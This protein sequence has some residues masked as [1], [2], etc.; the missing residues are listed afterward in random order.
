ML[1]YWN[2]PGAWGL[3]FGTSL[4]AGMAGVRKAGTTGPTGITRCG[5]T[6]AP[7]TNEFQRF[8]RAVALRA[9]GSALSF[10]EATRSSAAASMNLNRGSSRMLSKSGS[11]LA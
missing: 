6:W 3:G 7:I 2:F 1:D 4:E 10:S 11:I 8:C 5:N 9:G